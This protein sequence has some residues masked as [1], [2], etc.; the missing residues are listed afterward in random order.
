MANLTRIRAIWSGMPTGLGYSAFHFSGSLEGASLNAAAAAVRALFQGFVGD[1]PSFMRVEIEPLASVFDD[2]GR[3]E[4]ERVIGTLPAA[5]VGTAGTTAKVAAGVGA[6]I[7]W[8]TGRYSRGRPII[9]RTFLVPLAVT[10][11]DVDGT[12][13]P[14]LVTAL[15]T[16]ASNFRQAAGVEPVVWQKTGIIDLTRLNPIVAHNVSD[17][18]AVL[19][20]RR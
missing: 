20:S 4:A 3:K 13:N 18:V 12:L 14:G 7:S 19:T 9:G 11:Y 5:V 15:N 1:L 8:R 17:R 16:A 6:C 10:A 2:G